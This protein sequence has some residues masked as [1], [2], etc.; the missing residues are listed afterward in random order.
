M[1]FLLVE[2]LEVVFGNDDVSETQLLGLS[3][4]LLDAVH[5]TYLA[6]E[7]HFAAH[8]PAVVDGGIDIGGEYC[9][10]DA[11]IHSQVGD[12]Q[13]TGNIDEDILLHE[14]EAYALFK[15]SE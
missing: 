10:D 15:D 11:E 5:G 7:S 6:R 2:A 1:E 4:A 12:P 14:L 8:A 3:D 13:A 9:G